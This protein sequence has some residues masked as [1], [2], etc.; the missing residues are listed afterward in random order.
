MLGHLDNYV[1][2]GGQDHRSLRMLEQPYIKPDILFSKENMI[3]ILRRYRYENYKKILNKRSK[4]KVTKEQYNDYYKFTIVRNPWAR[5]Y[6]WYKNV[7]RDDIHIKN[8]KIV[9]RISL[10]V[11]LK[12]FA[13]KG[14]LKPQMY[15]IKNF[16]GSIPLNFIGKFENLS[17]D[18]N[19]V[20]K[21]LNIKNTSLPHKLKG[22]TDDY[23]IHYDQESIEIIQEVYEEEIELFKYKFE[24]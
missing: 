24:K 23:R 12:E 21:K 7:M 20:F 5:A 11:F 6:S 1:G 3:E 22:E 10:N 8:H 15:W 17:E 9:G 2:R 18:M 4:Y 13:G 14:H 16:N 19:T